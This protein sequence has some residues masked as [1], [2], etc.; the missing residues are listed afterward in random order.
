MN[1]EPKF[2]GYLIGYL[3][4][5][6]LTLIA[7]G[8]AYLHIN[9][10]HLAF[11]HQFLVYAVVALA[12]LQLYVQAVFFL[13]L[14]RHPEARYNL[15]SFI[16]TIFIVLFIVIGSLWIMN[17]LNYNMTADQVDAYLHKEN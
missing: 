8:L 7:F 13:H 5:V 12:V 17:N 14:S 1:H 6:A 10:G 16:F 11:S 3:L 9:S 15:V 2:H 4:S